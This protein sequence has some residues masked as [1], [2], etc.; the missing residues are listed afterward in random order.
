MYGVYAVYQE[1]YFGDTILIILARQNN[2]V[3][4]P[5]NRYLRCTYPTGDLQQ[6]NCVLRSDGEM[7]FAVFQFIDQIIDPTVRGRAVWLLVRSARSSFSC[8]F[9]RW[10]QL[11]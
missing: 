10:T 4:C 2:L 9:N 8:G 6:G 3:W 7:E 1:S 11:K 5:R